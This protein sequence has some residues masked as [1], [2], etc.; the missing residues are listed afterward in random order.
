VLR[1]VVKQSPRTMPF[2]TVYETPASVDPLL[3]IIAPQGRF[4]EL[5]VIS[6]SQVRAYYGDWGRNTSL[7]FQRVNGRWLVTPE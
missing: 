4:Y 1:I 3:K 5:S 6:E 7:L 2:T